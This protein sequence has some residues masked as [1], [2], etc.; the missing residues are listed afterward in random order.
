MTGAQEGQEPEGRT[1]A[2]A[3]EEYFMLACSL[4][5]LIPLCLEPK[6][7]STGVASPT[8]PGPFHINNYLRKCPTGLTTDLSYVGIFSVSRV[9]PQQVCIFQD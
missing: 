5:L 2:E 4:G 6:N 3:I 1:D 9:Q 7:I 8:V